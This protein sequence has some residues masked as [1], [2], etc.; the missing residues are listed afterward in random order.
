MLDA[1]EI[2]VLGVGA[3]IKLLLWPAY[4]STDF[5]VHRNWLAITGSLPVR[6]WYYEDRSE[7][8]LDYPPFFAWFEWALSHAARLWDPRIVDVDRLGYAAESCI[9]FQ[10]LTVLI[11]ELVLFM[12]LRRALRACGGDTAQGRIAAALVFLSP[13]FLLVDHVHFQ[14][15]GFL[16]G[17]LVYSLAFALE[18]RDLLAGAAFAVLLCFKHIF[19]YIAPAYFVY[20]L[21][22]YCVRGPG[23]GGGGGTGAAALRL[24]KLGS[25]VAAVF[26]A[27]F[28]PFV[29]MGQT[30]QLAARLFPFRRG[31]CHAFWAPNFWALYVAADRALAAAQFPRWLAAAAD[32]G[33]GPPQLH[34]A[35]R[36][37]VGDTRFVVLPDVPPLGAFVA[38]LAALAPAC[39]VLLQRR[40][41]P[42]QLVQA[43]VLCAHASFLFGWHVHEKAVILIVAPLGL[44]V[45][46]APSPRVLRMHTVLAAAGYFSLLPLLFGAQEL[47]IKAAVL[48][49]WMLCALALLR[50][51]GSSAWRCL[52][53]A[54]RLYVAG[55]APLFAL[56]ELAPGVFGR[57]QFMPLALVSVYAALGVTYAWLGIVA[58]FLWDPPP[59]P[60]AA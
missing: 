19:V 1:N 20:L 3:G 29:A 45:A 48:V 38:T 46:A 9:A 41:G 60:P 22:H 24:A 40:C 13:G 21:R 44:V 4:R 7:W 18:G 33:G 5:E 57:M 14:Y 25:V 17:I 54:E 35:T 42:A 32:A 51:D 12:A 53:R 36:G 6:Q 16:V 55:L 11:S 30:Q 31:L 10:R 56:T 58:A 2:A 47:P 34:S 23:G 50:A 43:V 37:R 39:A 28:G 59:P 27:A 26:G 15:N 8:T 52:M 49:I